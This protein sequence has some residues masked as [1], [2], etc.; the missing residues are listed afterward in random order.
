M[1]KRNIVCGVVSVAQLTAADLTGRTGGSRRAFGALFS[2]MSTVMAPASVVSH[3]E[4]LRIF[5]AEKRPPHANLLWGL[6]DMASKLATHLAKGVAKNCG[7]GG[8]SSR[9][10]LIFRG[11][12]RKAPPQAKSPSENDARPA[13]SRKLPLRECHPTWTCRIDFRENQLPSTQE[14]PPPTF[15][16][17]LY[18]YSMWVHRPIGQ[19]SLDSS[20]R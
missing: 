20:E 10:W 2:Q 11:G 5:G 15:C 19:L 8:G 4:P 12:T 13:C 1:R 16:C 3:A 6:S 7:G 18:M 17:G 9:W 14:C